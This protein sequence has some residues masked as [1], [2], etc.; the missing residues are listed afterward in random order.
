MKSPG[1]EVK[2]IKLISGNSPF[3]EVFFTDVVVPKDNLIGAKNKGWAIGKHLLL[4]E[5]SGIAGEGAGDVNGGGGYGLE[6]A[7]RDHIGLQDGVLADGGMRDRIADNKMFSH[8]FSLTA[9]RMS[10]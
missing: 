8:A 10:A 3:N 4:H 6:D 5:R 2:P 7:A 9:R 1:V